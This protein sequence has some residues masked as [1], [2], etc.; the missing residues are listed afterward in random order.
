[1]QLKV[2]LPIAVLID[3]PVT[4]VVAEAADGAFCLLPRHVDMA[5]ALVPGLLSFVA[6]DGAT[7]LLGI[8]EGMLV[9]CG[10][11]VRVVTLNAVRGD[12]L[13]TLRETVRRRFIELDEHERTAR[14]A[15]ARLEAGVVRRFLQLGER[16]R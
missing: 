2:L 11:E 16:T 15:L 13:A 5:A 3:E 4:K 7:G 8:D 9:K 1:M 14:S 6:A 12:D 10:A